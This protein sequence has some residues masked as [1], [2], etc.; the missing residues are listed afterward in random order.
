MPEPDYKAMYFHITGRVAGA[1]DA[2]E[3]TLDAYFDTFKAIIETLKKAQ[4]TTEDMFLGAGDN[5]PGE[6]E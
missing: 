1:I 6:S 4:I 5:K 3:D 2:L